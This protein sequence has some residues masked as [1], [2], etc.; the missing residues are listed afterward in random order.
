MD[1][2]EEVVLERFLSLLARD[3]VDVLLYLP[4]TH[5]LFY[6]SYHT[7]AYPVVDA[8]QRYY[9]DLAGRNGLSLLGSY[10]PVDCGLEESD[11]D[12]G[13]HLS[14]EGL[15]KMLLAQH[16]YRAR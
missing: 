14:D 13:D 11:F 8:A 16:C 7:S 5:P 4:P 10:N 6:S 15:A 3:H 1:R 12:D 2:S 9:E